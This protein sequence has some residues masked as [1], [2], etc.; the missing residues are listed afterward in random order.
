VLWESSAS[1]SGWSVCSRYSTESFE[2][3][4]HSP[5]RRS[6]YVLMDVL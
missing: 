3:G 5:W 4:S 1:L 6:K 2:A